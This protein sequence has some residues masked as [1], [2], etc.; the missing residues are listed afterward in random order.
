MLKKVLGWLLDKL[1]ENVM[2]IFKYC[3]CMLLIV[4]VVFGGPAMWVY[5][6]I[7][8]IMWVLGYWLSS[9]YLDIGKPT[10]TPLG[11]IYLREP[12]RKR[13][14]KATAILALPFGLIHVI[15]GLVILFGRYFEITS[16]LAFFVGDR[17][18]LGVTCLLGGIWFIVLNIMYLWELFS[19]K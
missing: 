8:L 1:I 13:L 10:R 15:K 7:L 16:A 5:S 14:L 17:V 19:E 2:E 3:M 6:V 9:T 11:V 18:E 12:P 4:G